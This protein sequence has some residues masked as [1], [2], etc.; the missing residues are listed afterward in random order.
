MKTLVV[1]PNW[2]GDALMA[3]PLLSLVKATDP[4]GAIVALAPRW[5]APVL[6]AM[7]EVDEVI[8]TN[9]AHGRLQWGERSAFARTLG[10]R[11]FDRAFVL[12]NSAKSALI[13]W[14]ARIPRR[15]GYVG[16]WRRGLVNARL[17]KPPPDRPMV[18][19]YAAL[20]GLA[21]IPVPETLPNPHLVADDAAI[22]AVR[23]KFGF[24][25]DDELVALCPGAE[26]GPAK[27]WPADHFA[28]LA[29]RVLDGSPRTHVVLLGGPGDRVIADEIANGAG[30]PVR[31]HQLA[32]STTL[33]EAIALI[34]ASANVVSNDSG[35]MHVAAALGRPQVAIFGSSDP[36]H[37]PPLSANAQV[38]WLHL[39]CSP[40]FQRT[41]PL[42][43]LNCLKQIDAERVF[44]SLQN[45]RSALN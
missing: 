41:C 30:S 42:G 44:D 12:P 24:A 27:R 22:V 36:R 32:G 16:E 2:I 43:H 3:Q 11:G 33:D 8:G 9:L 10:E 35:L 20:A 15:I 39:D 28:A 18:A 13:P 34:A 14:L 1:A 40:C 17:P 23:A 25:P 29:R 38:L 19:R 21:G 26:Y 45:A 6:A 37:T 7:P 31:V 4:G 5:V